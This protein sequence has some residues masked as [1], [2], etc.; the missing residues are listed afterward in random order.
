MYRKEFFFIININ[1]TG[2]NPH[3]LPFVHV[4]MRSSK[5]VGEN[6]FKITHQYILSFKI[7][8]IFILMYEHFA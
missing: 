6:N 4:D 8:F 3:I 5:E 1:L 2:K 7:R